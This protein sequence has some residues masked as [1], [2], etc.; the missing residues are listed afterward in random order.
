MNFRVNRWIVPAEYK[1]F[2]QTV[3]F[4]GT[5]GLEY[6]AYQK[7]PTTLERYLADNP[8]F[9]VVETDEFD[10]LVED[11][12]YSRCT[13]WQPCTKAHWF[14][15][16]EVLPPCRWTRF[17]GGE[18]F[19]VSERITGNLVNWYMRKGN[20]YFTRVQFA[21]QNLDLLVHGGH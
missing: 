5:D 4:I 2:A 11:Y 14:D 10:R 21:D 6:V 12:E 15:M 8:G 7:Q 3:T 18:I 16:L 9:R 17:D 13:K 1:G 20:N 19:H